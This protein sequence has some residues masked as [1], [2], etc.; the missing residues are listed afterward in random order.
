MIENTS[1]RNVVVLALGRAARKEIRSI[2]SDSHDSILRMK[3]KTALELFSWERVWREMQMH[4]PL[5][6]T[7]LTQLLPLSKR[8]DENAFHPALSVCASILLT[9]HN[10]KINIVQAVIAVVLRAGHAT[11]QVY[12]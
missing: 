9:L 11:K 8:K 6:V 1:L 7:F 4:A 12:I 5:L 2:C 10:F 3:N